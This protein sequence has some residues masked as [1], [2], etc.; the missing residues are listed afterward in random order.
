MP[1]LAGIVVAAALLGEVALR[2]AM[3][4]AQ[5]DALSPP[6]GRMQLFPPPEDRDLFDD[7]FEPP[8]LPD[9]RQDGGAQEGRTS[10]WPTLPP[11]VT[12]DEDRIVLDE[13]PD[14]GTPCGIRVVPADPSVDPQ[15]PRAFSDP[16]VHHTIRVVPVPPCDPS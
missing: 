12:T 14:T 6:E 16:A 8:A 15:M 7:L 2:P 1:N 9:S 3:P 13:V 10:M 5:P 4:V 11:V